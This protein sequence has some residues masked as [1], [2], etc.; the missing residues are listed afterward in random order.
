MG[1]GELGVGQLC[2]DV[3]QGDNKYAASIP[4]RSLA[5]GLWGRW[6]SV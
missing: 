2:P 5:R 4:A 6:D 1:V 3:G